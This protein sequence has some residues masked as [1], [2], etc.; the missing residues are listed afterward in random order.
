ML[1]SDG[2][3]HATAYHFMLA[4]AGAHRQYVALP[5]LS[6]EAHLLYFSHPVTP[7][8][9]RYLLAPD[10][11]VRGAAHARYTSAAVEFAPTLTGGES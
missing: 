10:R 3:E 4:E 2:W 11:D 1:D 6:D 8:L 7:T 9:A 5:T